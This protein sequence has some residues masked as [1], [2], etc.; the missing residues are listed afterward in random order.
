MT[1]YEV[2][3]K[4]TVWNKRGKR[5]VIQFNKYGHIR[6]SVEAVK[7]LGLK[8]KMTISFMTS[9][10]DVGVIYFFS[11]K[12]GMALRR[13]NGTKSGIR[14]EIICRPLVL[15]LLNFFSYETNKT[16]DITSETI[17]INDRLSW[18]ILKEKLHRPIKWR[19]T[20]SNIL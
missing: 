7:L 10:A 4:E 6:F 14:L 8:E 1:K 15:K 17:K 18:F 16:F 3:N 11:D 19:K 5:P 20:Q 9:P 2:Y 12:K 13:G